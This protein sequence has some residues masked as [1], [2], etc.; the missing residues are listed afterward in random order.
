M[1]RLSVY[2]Q[3]NS[4]DIL[5][6]KKKVLN[7]LSDNAVCGENL[8]KCLDTTGE[9]IDPST[10]KAFLSENL[11]NL[12][13]LLQEPVGN[14]KWS[15]ITKN[16]PFVNFINSKKEF[17]KPAIEQCQD[18]ADTVWKDFLDDALSQIKL[19]QNA[20]MEEIRQSCTTLVAE[21][22]TNA[23]TD[24]SEFDS[25]ALS[26]F[27]VAADKT[28]NEMCSKIQNSC[29]SLMG[30]NSGDE[31]QS[32]MTNIAT[33]VTYK[34]IIDTC[35][36]IGRDC[37]IQ[38]CNGAS[39]N[40]ALCK[41]TNS[42]NRIAILKREACWMEVY[43]CVRSADNLEN[44]NNLPIVADRSNYYSTMYFTTTPN[45]LPNWCGPSNDTAC[46]I[47]EQIWGNCETNNDDTMITNLNLPDTIPHNKILIPKT[48]STL[49]SWLAINTGTQ[50]D[51][52]DS[53]N[54]YHCP[55]NYQYN[56]GT[57]ICQQ[58]IPNQTTDGG[59]ATNYNQVI[60]ISPDITNYC[61]N[62]VRDMFGNCC[63]NGFVATNERICVPG[64]NYHALRLVTD[65]CIN[66][67]NYYCPDYSQ[68]NPRKISVYCITTGE[69]I[70]AQDT[71]TGPV[72][73]YICPNNGRWVLIDQYGNYFNVQ[74][75]TGAP[76]MSYT[77]A[78]STQHT[79]NSNTWTTDDPVVPTNAEFMIT[80]Q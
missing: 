70:Q 19:A 32:G 30:N 7:Q 13:N 74:G 22:K 35:T 59:F 73:T 37:I 69:Y 24:L 2:Q 21:C 14:E 78:D 20:K 31:W 71:G 48:G 33:D 79:Y 57:N 26:M 80:Y 49:L 27:S 62:G 3:R 75:Q 67:D 63:G 5:T 64:N 28:A 23:L 51:T 38:K 17:L 42:D 66:D 12:V 54:T 6:C 47:A 77:D 9:Y 29:V 60:H 16:E 15:K 65:T 76:S 56:S 41:N 53:C 68:S 18:V 55:V 61:E 58:I 50:Q 4:D 10:G 8:Y 40:F 72:V 43:N 1:S 39:G 44:M 45:T 11:Y 34:S 25:R 52:I 46:L 36:Q